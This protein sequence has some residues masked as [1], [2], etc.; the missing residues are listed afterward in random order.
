MITR[1]GQAHIRLFVAQKKQ[2]PTLNS[3]AATIAKPSI[4]ALQR[5][6]LLH[7]T[8]FRHSITLWLAIVYLNYALTGA[9]QESE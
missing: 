9:H 3:K 2:T 5:V 4:A 7:N 1:S 6:L 8:S